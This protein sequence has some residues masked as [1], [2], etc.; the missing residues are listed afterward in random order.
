[1]QKLADPP[2]YALE[3]NRT[4]TESTDNGDAQLSR[5]VQS[6]VYPI[7]AENA[8]LQIAN[9][10]GDYA[11][12]VSEHLTPAQQQKADVLDPQMLDLA[13]KAMAGLIL[14]KG[15]MDMQSQEGE[16]M[17][18]M[19][20][21]AYGKEG[22]AGVQKLIDAVNKNLGGDFKVEMKTDPA[23][24]KRII[25]QFNKIGETPPE[26]VGNIE[27]KDKSGRPRGDVLFLY[28]KDKPGTKI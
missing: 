2:N 23:L 17:F 7:K 16:M 3:N 18:L 20:H 6:A 10:Y 28:G 19:A 5:F 24:T 15:R 14:N 13:G 22:A 11:L 26:F 12:K 27:L 9:Q 25:E 4:A 21:Q 8:N 1:M